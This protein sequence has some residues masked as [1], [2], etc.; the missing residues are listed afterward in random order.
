MNYAYEYD[1][2]FDANTLQGTKIQFSTGSMPPIAETSLQER[3]SFPGVAPANLAFLG[4]G[5]RCDAVGDEDL[6][7]QSLG[8]LEHGWH[9]LE[10]GPFP[11]SVVRRKL[12][13]LQHGHTDLAAVV[14]PQRCNVHRV[15]AGEDDRRCW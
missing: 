12:H 1:F 2:N 9:L 6:Q 8:R 5:V 10:R 15:R 7:W 11:P 4:C 3:N 14:R 13:L